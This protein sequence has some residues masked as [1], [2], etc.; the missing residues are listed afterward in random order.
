MR[1]RIDAPEERTKGATGASGTQLKAVV[2]RRKADPEPIQCGG[3]QMATKLIE[4]RLSCTNLRE[5]L[6]LIPD[7]F[8][9]IRRI[10]ITIDGTSDSAIQRRLSASVASHPGYGEYIVFDGPG[11]A[12]DVNIIRKHLTVERS[13]GT[14]RIGAIEVSSMAEP[15][16]K[17]RGSDDP[18][19]AAEVFAMITA[20]ISRTIDASLD[21]L[22]LLATRKSLDDTLL[23]CGAEFVSSGRGFSAILIDIDH[24]KNINDSHGHNG[25]DLVLANVAGVLLNAMRGVCG[26]SIDSVG[27]YGGEEFLVL[28]QGVALRDAVVVAERLRNAVREHSFAVSQSLKVGLSCS[29]GV[30]ETGELGE[31][32]TRLSAEEAGAALVALADSRLY[33]AKKNGRDRVEPLPA[34]ALRLVVN[35]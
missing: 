18:G 27:R 30:A 22:T 1:N 7:C 9:G 15:T 31:E 14:E 23:S 6:R 33:N 20:L 2:E 21:G 28:L 13:S 5:L 24:F 19:E 29:F 35:E 16:L 4:K 3:R 12:A 34:G 10:D 32:A 11:E 25:G 8:E 26:F 17:L